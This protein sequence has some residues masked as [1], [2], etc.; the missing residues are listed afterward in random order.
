MP[1]KTLNNFPLVLIIFPGASEVP[2][3]IEPIITA[4]APAANA[5]AMSPENL[6]P[7]SEIIFTFLF[8]PFLTSNK[9]LSCGTPIPAISLVVQMKPGPMPT[10][11]TSTPSLHKNL[12]ASAV[13]IFPAHSAV[14]F[15]LIFFIFN[16]ISATF[17]LCPWAVS[18]TIKSISC[19]TIFF[20]L[21][22]SLSLVPTAAP[23][24]NF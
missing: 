6:I 9:A 10:F 3:S 11:I 5:F 12:A 22:N 23:T 20:A 2:A 24:F 4:S 18:T 16:I 13:A 19:L 14:F 17:W 8:N 15:D 21:L 7:P 1:L